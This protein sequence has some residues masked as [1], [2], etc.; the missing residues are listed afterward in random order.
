MKET[1][2]KVLKQEQVE[3]PEKYEEIFDLVKANENY[4]IGIAGKVIS[5]SSFATKEEAKKYI[6]SKPWELI[7]N[8]ACLCMDLSKQNNK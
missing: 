5:K 3:K 7:I 1:K 4:Y 8:A 6:D 2:P